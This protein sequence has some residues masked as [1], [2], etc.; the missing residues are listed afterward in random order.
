MAQSIRLVLFGPSTQTRA[1]VISHRMFPWIVSS[2][3]SALLQE[4]SDGKREW[5]V[6]VL[7]PNQNSSRTSLRCLRNSTLPLGSNMSMRSP[8]LNY[9]S[10]LKVCVLRAQY[11]SVRN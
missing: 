5:I 6:V 7:T 4:T 3:A 9:G 2:R 8:K 11:H 1:H 10:L